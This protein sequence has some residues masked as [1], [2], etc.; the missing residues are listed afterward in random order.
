MKQRIIIVWGGGGGGGS[1]GCVKSAQN[2]STCSNHYCTETESLPGP[3]P[4]Q[5][6]FTGYF[7]GWVPG[8]QPAHPDK[9]HSPQKRRKNKWQL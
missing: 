3:I 4:E 2:E 6:K 8:L 9:T 5:N 7:S 1:K